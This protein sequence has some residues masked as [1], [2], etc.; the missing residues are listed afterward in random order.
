[1]NPIKMTPAER[2]FRSHV[3]AHLVNFADVIDVTGFVN[4]QHWSSQR[5]LD[6]YMDVLLDSP[7]IFYVSKAVQISYAQRPDGSFQN[8][9]LMG[10]RYAFNKGD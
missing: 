7:D 3:L 4:S 5:V 9:K 2:S 1:M 10:I 8:C 6:L